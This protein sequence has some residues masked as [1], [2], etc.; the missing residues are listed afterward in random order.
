MSSIFVVGDMLLAYSEVPRKKWLTREPSGNGWYN[1]GGK[2]LT[3]FNQQKLKSSS[4]W[5][6]MQIRCTRFG[7]T[8]RVN[9]SKS[10]AE[11]DAV[12]LFKNYQTYCEWFHNEVTNGNYQDGFELDHNLL[13]PGTKIYSPETCL[14]LPVEIN[15]VVVDSRR[16]IHGCTGIYKKKTKGFAASLVENGKKQHLGTFNTV[17][18]AS[19]AYIA[20]KTDYILRLAEKWRPSISKTAYEALKNWRPYDVRN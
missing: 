12:D 17:E 15:R 4:T 5:E 14:W 2:Y 9:R 1:P 7:K 8:L 10:Y 3:R 20:A 18:E 11:V 19:A 6:N 13:C 16:N